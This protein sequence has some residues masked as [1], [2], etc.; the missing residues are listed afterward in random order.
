MVA[1]TPII[2]PV[3]N[4]VR[5]FDPKLLLA[6]MAARRGF[7]TVIGS[8][9]EIDFRIAAFPRA[10]YLAKS[11]TARSVKMFKIMRRLGHEIAVW[12]EEALVHM[13]PDTYFTRR[14]S[15]EAI[16]HVSHLFAW[17][18]ENAELWRQYPHL[19]EHMPL[20]ITGNPRGDLLRPELHPYFAADARKIHDT[21]GDYIL[22]NTNFSMVNAYVPELNL[23]VPSQKTR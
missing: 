13:Q 15:A 19:P 6:V 3:E 22:I 7:P 16:R 21:Y 5:E 2:I 10:I 14:L 12:D 1:K 8:R 4:Q 9:L 17:G 23:F 18:R 11:M 20:H